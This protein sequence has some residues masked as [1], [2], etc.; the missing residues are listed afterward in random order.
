MKA[1]TSQASSEA[2]SQIQDQEAYVPRVKPVCEPIDILQQS[3][4]MIGQKHH[5]RQEPRRPEEHERGFKNSTKIEG[6]QFLYNLCSV[7]IAASIRCKGS[8]THTA[9]DICIGQESSYGTAIVENR[10][11]WFNTQATGKGSCKKRKPEVASIMSPPKVPTPSTV[12]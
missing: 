11:F 6:V 8:S 12:N 3:Q 4:Q 1:F 7:R 5:Q 9:K 2:R 10:N